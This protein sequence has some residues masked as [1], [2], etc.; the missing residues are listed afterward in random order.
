MATNGVQS[1]VTTVRLARERADRLVAEGKVVEAGRLAKAITGGPMVATG[2]W[3]ALCAIYALAQS[4]A[5]VR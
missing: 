1:L 2:D 5:E 3:D 4:Y